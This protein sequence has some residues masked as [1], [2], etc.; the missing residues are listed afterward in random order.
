MTKIPVKSG[1]LGLG[2]HKMQ[3]VCAFLA[4]SLSSIE[5]LSGMKLMSEKDFKY[6]RLDYWCQHYQ[7]QVIDYQ[8]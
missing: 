5:F 7:Y 6:E 1:G 2:D 8:Y 4:S 3:S